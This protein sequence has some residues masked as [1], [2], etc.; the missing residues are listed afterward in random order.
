M[1]VKDLTP[2]TVYTCCGTDL[3]SVF[4]DSQAGGLCHESHVL[5]SLRLGVENELGRD[6]SRTDLNVGR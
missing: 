3:W 2:G 6:G 4:V 1:V 5:A